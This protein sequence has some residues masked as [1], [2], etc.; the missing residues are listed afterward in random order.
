M[1]KKATGISLILL[2][3]FS[4]ILVCYSVVYDN[5]LWLVS[6]AMMF[7]AGFLTFNLDMDGDC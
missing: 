7:I 6:F 1:N 5:L 3:Y 2:A 4:G